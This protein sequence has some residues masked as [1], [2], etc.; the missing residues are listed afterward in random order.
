MRVRG[1]L[2]TKPAKDRRRKIGATRFE[3]NMD[4]HV[5][6]VN[7]QGTGYEGIGVI[8]NLSIRGAL[9]ETHTLV[10]T[11]DQLKLFVTLPNEADLLEIP[12]VAVRWVR[13]QQAGV[14][15]LKLPA[16]TS[17]K[18]MTCLAGIHTEARAGLSDTPSS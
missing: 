3:V 6:G 11:D 1:N 4:V 17:L 7:P 5:S 15:F 12:T 13:G 16:A 18:L 9:I 2:M 8:R 14:E 10:T